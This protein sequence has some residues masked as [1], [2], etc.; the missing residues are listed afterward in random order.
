MFDDNVMVDLEQLMRLLEES[1][2][3]NAELRGI[4][5]ELVALKN[6]GE[7]LR[8]NVK[9]A[10]AETLLTMGARLVERR[11]RIMELGKRNKACDL[12]NK[13]VSLEIGWLLQKHPEWHQE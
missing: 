3:I 7:A 6:E 1:E 12:R 11:E 8:E 2:A 13:Q 4:H 9:T 10:D 5:E